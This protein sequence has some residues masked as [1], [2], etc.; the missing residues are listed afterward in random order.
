MSDEKK[1]SIR[2]EEDKIILRALIDYYMDGFR[3]TS[4]TSY[5]NSDIL[6]GKVEKPKPPKDV[7]IRKRHLK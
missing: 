3:S 7:K 4:M 6:L 5:V 2:S 1:E